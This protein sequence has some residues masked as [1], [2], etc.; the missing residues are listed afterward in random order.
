MKADH[1]RWEVRNMKGKSDSPF[2]Y[3]RCTGCGCLQIREVPGDL[4]RYYQDD[5]YSFSPVSDRKLYDRGLKKHLRR[6][7]STMALSGGALGGLVRR[8]FSIPE[9]YVWFRIAGVDKTSRILDSGC[10]AGSLLVRI[11]KEGF[12]GAVGADPFIPAEIR[13]PNGLVIMKKSLAEIGE[14]SSF[15][16]IMM[17]HSFEHIPDQ[18]SAMG[19]LGRLLKPSGA[20]MLRVPLSSSTAWERYGGDWVQLSPPEHLYLH[21]EKSMALLAER[22]GFRVKEVLYDSLGF[23]FWASELVSRG[24]PL[25]DHRKEAV[26]FSKKEM[27]RFEAEA[28]KANAERKGDMACFFLERA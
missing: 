13:Y 27:E 7:T 2:T 4:A 20:V 22:Y 19:E 21:T 23:Q 12:T 26:R 18:G 15:D 25:Q 10:G 11:R 9:H 5:Y 6:A 14:S 28:R 3:F 24:V 17:N 1:P 16:F 8:L